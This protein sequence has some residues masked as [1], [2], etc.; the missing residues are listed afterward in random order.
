M[1][2]NEL[3][4][5]LREISSYCVTKGKELGLSE[6]QISEMVRGVMRIAVR[7]SFKGE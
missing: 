3:Y 1:E 2:Q 6:E 4:Y 5:R 7:E